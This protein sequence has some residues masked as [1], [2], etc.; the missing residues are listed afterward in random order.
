MVWPF[1][2]YFAGWAAGR[3]GVMHAVRAD[4]RDVDR[5]MMPA[6]LNHPWRGRRR[7]AEQRNVVLVESETDAAAS[8]SAS[9][10]RPGVRRSVRRRSS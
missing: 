1:N 7:R 5:E 4:D 10:V 3:L 2:V 6:E 8:A 9:S